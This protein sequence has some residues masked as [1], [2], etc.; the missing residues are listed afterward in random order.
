[1][2]LPHH[3]RWPEIHETAF[4][5]PSADVIGDVKI[6]ADSSLWFQTVV[7]GDVNTIEIGSKTN[8]QD[9]STLHVTRKVSPLKVGDEVTVGHRVILHGCTV[10]NRCLIGMGAIVMD[11]AVIGDESIVAAGALV[12]KGKKF[13]PR[14]L[15][16][17][18]PARVAREVTKEELEFLPKSAA[19]YVH[20][21][22]EYRS[23]VR[24]PARHG[25]D[26]ADLEA[27]FLE[28]GEEV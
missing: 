16:M 25:M 7:R 3:G 6:G 19:N 20:D 2:I 8:V 12:T 24:G 17:G 26:N 13:P 28:E 23:Y 21:G 4:V 1:M 9:H 27:P 5:A 14:S 11:D 18:S 22:Q 10:G 15:I